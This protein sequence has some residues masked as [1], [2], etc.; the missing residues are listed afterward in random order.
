MKRWRLWG[1]DRP[2]LRARGPG[3]LHGLHLHPHLR[4]QDAH[5]L[6][7]HGGIAEGIAALEVGVHLPVPVAYPR[8]VFRDR[9]SGVAYGGQVLDVVEGCAA[10]GLER[11]RGF[12]DGAGL[13][14][15]ALGKI[16]EHHDVGFGLVRIAHQ[17]RELDGALLQAGVHADNG[18]QHHVLDLARHAAEGVADGKGER[19]G[20]EALDPPAPAPDRALGLPHAPLEVAGVA[21]EAAFHEGGDAVGK[22]RPLTLNAGKG[23]INVAGLRAEEDQDVAKGEAH[24]ACSSKGDAEHVQEGGRSHGGRRVSRA[25]GGGSCWGCPAKR[26]CQGVDHCVGDEAGLELFASSVGPQQQGKVEV[27]EL[28][29]RAYAP[30]GAGE[31]VEVAG[32]AGPRSASKRTKGKA[33]F[34]S[35]MKASTTSASRA[36]SSMT[37][38]CAVRAGA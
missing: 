32:V 17:G 18:A 5:L 7:G 31:F 23:R 2:D 22:G 16:E 10:K 24:E 29:A 27:V 12:D 9:R 13:K 19:L 34:N 35:A 25:G 3:A 4:G 37:S 6:E 21:R 20:K 11:A 1:E 8:D 15:G 14:G 36:V 26:R 30:C 38:R 33:A 28:L